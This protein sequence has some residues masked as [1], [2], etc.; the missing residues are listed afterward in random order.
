MDTFVIKWQN[1]IDESALILKL[2]EMQVALGTL[3]CPVFAMRM[4][5]WR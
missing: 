5:I 3:N 4:E 2:K 1:C